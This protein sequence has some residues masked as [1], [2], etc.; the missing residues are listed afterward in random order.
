MWKGMRD[1]M[2]SASPT[3]SA[4]TNR[5]GRPKDWTEPRTRRLIRLYVFTNL[6]FPNILK[7]LEEDEFKPGYVH[8]R[9]TLSLPMSIASDWSV[10]VAAKTRPTR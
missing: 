6:P 5:G 4:S 10:C 2:D 7:L 9:S 3:A 1:A 8:T